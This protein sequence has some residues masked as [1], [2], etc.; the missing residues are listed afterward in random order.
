M[1]TPIILASA[2]PRRR[3]LLQ[4]VGYQ[5]DVRPA[6]LD[7]TDLP[8]E[9]PDRYVARIARAKATAIADT[10]PGQWV[11]AAD[12]TVTI[13]GLILAKAAT[14]DE[15]YAMLQRLSGRTH[16]VMTGFAIFGPKT[17]ERVVTSQVEF[18]TLSA[19]TIEDYI[20]CGEWQGKAGAYALQGIGAALVR[21]VRGSV[22]N[23]IGLPLV[24]VIAGFAD[25]GGPAPRFAAGSA[26]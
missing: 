5:L 11:L 8:G 4:R 17:Y 21:A 19:A 10:A 2:S 7:E 24:E 18:V 20:A 23:V 14:P 1:T 3:D 26:V 13:D 16:Q 25:V 6:D 22:T 15:A 9:S 12:T